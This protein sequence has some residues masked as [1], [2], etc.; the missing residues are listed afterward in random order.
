[1]ATM[2]YYPNYP[3]YSFSAFN[4]HLQTHQGLVYGH[5][6]PPPSSWRVPQYARAALMPK[7]GESKP[8]LAKAE[9]EQLEAEFQKN[10]KPN[11]SVKKGLAEHMRVDIARINVLAP[12][13]PS[14]P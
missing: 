2:S 7:S 4:G 6:G 12:P 1:M 14:D 11:S 10:H 5:G 3:M 9:V 8:R 13:S